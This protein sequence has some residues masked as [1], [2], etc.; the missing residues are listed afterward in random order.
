MP[1]DER[2]G[3]AARAARAAG[4]RAEGVGL[5]LLAGEAGRRGSTRCR[6]RPSRNCA[7]RTHSG[8]SRCRSRRRSASTNLRDAL[9]VDDRRLHGRRHRP[10][11]RA[12][13]R[14]IAAMG[15]RP[16]DVLHNAYGYGLF[17]GGLGLHYA[18]SASARPSSPPPAATSRSSSSSSP[19]SARPGSRARRRSRC[20]SPSAPAR[21]ARAHRPALRRLRRRALVGGSAREARGGVGIDACDMYGLS[22]VMGPAS[23]PSAARGRARSTSSTTTS[24]R[25]SSTADDRGPRRARPDDADEG[26]FAGDPVPHG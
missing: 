22:E 19:T 2:A 17:T 9:Q 8:R 5:A 11:R 24:C 25:R 21:S 26:G 15:G 7:T 16:G 3:L 20:F 13:R 18:A 10:V 6:S 14:A 4:R 1:A 23:P 12:E